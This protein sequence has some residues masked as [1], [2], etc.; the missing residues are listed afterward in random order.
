MKILVIYPDYEKKITGGQVYDHYFIN[1]LSACKNVSISICKEK[2]KNYDSFFALFSYLKLLKTAKKFDI[3]ISNSRYYSK[4]LLLFF[5]LKIVFSKKIILFHHH[6]SFLTESGM[7]QKL[8]RW[9][10]LSFLK[11]TSQIVIPSPYVKKLME[12]LLPKKKIIYI[13]LAFKTDNETSLSTLKNGNKLLFVG[14]IEPRK[15]IIFL[16]QSLHLLKQ[17]NVDFFCSIVGSVTDEP[18]YQTLLAYITE[19]SLSENVR[20]FGRVPNIEL[21]NLYTAS[22]CFVFPSQHEGFGMVLIE[23]MSHGLPVVAFDNS[24]IPYT[25]KNKEN[26]L[27]IEDKN[28]VKFGEA[29]KN[30]LE[31]EKLRTELGK[32]AYDTY[33]NSYSYD[34]LNKDIDAFAANLKKNH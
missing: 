20:F 28:T 29:I 30:V 9:F 19:N 17:Q 33:L 11:Q 16:L 32:N 12:K 27:L 10:E 5:I 7:K 24:A 4:F 13:P 22:D 8:H 1:R 6:F 3:V 23:A 31:N 25:I 26:G 34:E 2:T 21:N 18:Y 14:T 15:G